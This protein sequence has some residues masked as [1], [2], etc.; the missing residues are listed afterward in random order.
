MSDGY[1]KH[2]RL[3]GRF[4][5]EIPGFGHTFDG[6]VWW[7]YA[8]LAWRG[9][10]VDTRKYIRRVLPVLPNVRVQ[11]AHV[12]TRTRTHTHTHIL[13]ICEN[14]NASLCEVTVDT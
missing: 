13:N 4:A 2:G 14:S 3:H 10:E 7:D 1:A 12:H 9:P 6:Q 5:G 11:N 8:A